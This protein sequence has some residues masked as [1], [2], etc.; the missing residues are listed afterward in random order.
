MGVIVANILENIH[1]I[2]DD[3]TV[4]PADKF[5]R[6]KLIAKGY[7]P[8]LS[9]ILEDYIH[10]NEPVPT[11]RKARIKAAKRMLGV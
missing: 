1:A 9:Q 11:H 4:E 5:M 7:A 10:Q 8:M 2:C 3:K 6:I